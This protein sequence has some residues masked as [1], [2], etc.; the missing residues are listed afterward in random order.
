MATFA[1]LA[2]VSGVTE[3]LF[4]YLM[5]GF[6]AFAVAT[7][8]QEFFRGT[9]ARRAM[10]GD[11]VPRALAGLIARNRRRY[12]GYIVHA[13]IVMLAVGVAGSSAYQTK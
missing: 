5:F 11:S 8:A 7:V 13:A 3:H 4:A 12:G 2:L 1:G 6:G 9:R 10:T